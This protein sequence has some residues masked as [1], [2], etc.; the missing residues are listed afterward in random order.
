[1]P[2]YLITVIARNGQRFAGIRFCEEYNIDKAWQLFEN[3]A[4]TNTPNFK[5]FDLVMISKRS[6]AYKDWMTREQKKHNPDVDMNPFG[7]VYEK[8][9]E[10][11]RYS[12]NDRQKKSDTA[13]NWGMNGSQRS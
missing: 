3:L 6:K 11:I 8:G 10:E 1:M 7:N 4:S 2:Y 13:K 9:K 12:S 5:S